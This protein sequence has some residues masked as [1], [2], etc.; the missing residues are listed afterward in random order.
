M[1]GRAPHRLEVEHVHS[2][3]IECGRR[4]RIETKTIADRRRLAGTALLLVVRRKDVDCFFLGAG[5]RNG[6]A[7]EH[8]PSRGLDRRLTEIFVVGASNSFAQ[9]RRHRHDG[10]ALRA[11]MSTLNPKWSC[12]SCER[13][14]T[15]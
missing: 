14:A 8:Q 1:V 15:K 5:D 2:G 9:L 10:S 3:A 12:L 6:D 7:V 11:T 13:P 4:H